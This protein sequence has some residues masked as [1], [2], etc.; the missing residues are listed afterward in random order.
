MKS[1]INLKHKKPGDTSF[2][3]SKRQRKQSK[4]GGALEKNC[5]A[6]ISE[7]PKCGHE[8]CVYLDD[9]TNNVTKKQWKKQ[10]QLNSHGISISG[11]RDAALHSLAPNIIS[12]EMKPCDL[13]SIK[14][15]ENKAPCFV[16][17]YRHTRT[18]DKILYEEEKRDSWCRSYGTKNQC[19]VDKQMYD[20]FKNPE[21]NKVSLSSDG[22]ISQLIKQTLP[23][24]DSASD[25]NPDAEDDEELGELLND[26][27]IDDKFTLINPYFLTEIKMNRI[28]GI[29]INELIKEMYNILGY[30]VTMTVSGLWSAETDKIIQN[31][32][33]LGYT[34]SDFHEGN[35]MIDVDDDRLCH[36]ID[37]T[38]KKTKKPITPND[39]KKEFKKESIFKI[40]DWGI[41][42]RFSKDT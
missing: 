22:R 9:D 39:I 31:I 7:F 12:T 37:E 17:R 2:K 20:K 38:L 11:Q 41:L 23:D 40:V 1:R 34:S 35:I 3:K 36:W 16:K 21:L 25:G 42:N 15:S 18:G 33:A 10:T 6:D 26:V 13:I 14:G 5:L 4:R 19:V 28:K 24:V 29:T 30:D 8:G 27:L 32:A